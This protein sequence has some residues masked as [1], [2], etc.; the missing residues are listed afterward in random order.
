MHDDRRAPTRFRRAAAAAATL[1]LAFGG[2]STPSPSFADPRDNF[3]GIS[4]DECLAH[5]G[6]VDQPYGSPIRAC[7]IDTP[8]SDI[9]GIKGCYIC[10]QSWKNCVWEPAATAATLHRYVAPNAGVNTGPNGAEPNPKPRL[11]RPATA[12]ARAP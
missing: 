3:P 9:T 8:G 7:C 10:D 1:A 2:M 11:P 5:G 12:G 6:N 4:L